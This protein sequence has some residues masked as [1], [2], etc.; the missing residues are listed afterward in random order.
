MKAVLLA[1]TLYVAAIG[2]AYSQRDILSPERRDIEAIAMKYFEAINAGEAEKAAS[3]FRVDGMLVGLTGRIV[4]GT[5]IPEYLAKVHRLGVHVRLN[6]EN[7]EPLGGGLGYDASAAILTGSFAA[8][9]TD[10]PEVRGTLV[11]LYEKEVN[12]GWM[13]RASIASK[14]AF[15]PPSPSTSEK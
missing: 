2:A 1:S 7:V 13:L 5:A 12:S 3:M 6:V 11:Q 10:A 15:P 4:K 14:F 8:T 9:F